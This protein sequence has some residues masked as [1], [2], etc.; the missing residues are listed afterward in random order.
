M[1]DKLDGMV[2]NGDTKSQ[3]F[4]H[5]YKLYAMHCCFTFI[6]QTWSSCITFFLAALTNNSIFIV[7][8]TG[9][10]SALAT[11]LLSPRIG[12]WADRNDRLK[13][14]QIAI[15]VKIVGITGAYILC[16]ILLSSA[17]ATDED[18][19]KDPN[20][21]QK[22]YPA[23]VY[24]IPLFVSLTQVAYNTLTI[25]I[26][27]DWIVVLSGNST[28]WLTQTNSIMTIIDLS[29]SSLAPFFAG[30][31]FSELN[32]SILSCI[33]LAT[34]LVCSI[35]LVMFLREIYY[36]WPLLHIRKKEE[37][38][39]LLET[40]KRSISTCDT[41]FLKKM[42]FEFS[43]SGCLLVMISFSCLFLTVLSFGSI[44]TGNYIIKLDHTATSVYIHVIPL[45]TMI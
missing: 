10:V 14:V 19:V 17:A 29:S 35:C 43:R 32:L 22:S 16:S 40:S 45:P 7:S 27:K 34:N 23:V 38:I 37:E 31:L 1:K 6:S 33:L 21:T 18:V 12:Q 36:S 44:M 5:R 8:F 30:I 25:C 42:W 39:V 24:L 26:E 11:L 20:Q 15:G 2:D 28:Q 3:S 41:L 13:V 9:F 4:R